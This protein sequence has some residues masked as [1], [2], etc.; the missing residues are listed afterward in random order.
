LQHEP[1]T[2]VEVQPNA[3]LQIAFQPMRSPIANLRHVLESFQI[4]EA[5]PELLGPGPSQLPQHHTLFSTQSSQSVVF[6]GYLHIGL[7]STK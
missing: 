4:L 6:E 2:A 7:E 1:A 3:V 5:S